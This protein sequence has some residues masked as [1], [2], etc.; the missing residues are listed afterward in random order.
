MNIY[1]TEKT[2]SN[3]VKKNGKLLGIG[4]A[5]LL[6]LAAF[7]SGLHIGSGGSIKSP[8]E[9]GLLTFFSSWSEPNKEAD[10]NEFWR[11][12]NLL[13]K[14]FVASTSTDPV[15][16]SDRI[17]GAIEGLVGSYGDPYTLFL[18]PE[19]AAEFA[20][21]IGGEFSGVGMEVGLRNG[22][23]TVI[24]PLSDSPAEKAGVLSG[25]VVVKIDGTA[26]DGMS[27]EEAVRLIRGE[28][29]S[30]VTL[31]IYRE[32]ELEFKDIEITRDLITIPTVDTEVKNGVYIIRLYNFNALSETKMQEAL[33][34]Y[35]R[36]RYKKL[37]LDLRG[38]PGGY[39]Q[40]AI[41]IA[42][43]FLPEGSAV[44]RE[45]FGENI[46]EQVYRS[47]GKKVANFNPDNLVVLIDG[48]SAS[49]SEILAGALSEQK[50]ATT[51]GT[52]TF[53]KGSV[54]ELIKLPSG[55][56]LKVTVARWLT[57]NGISLSEDGLDPMV[58][59]SRTP[60]QV[61]ADEDP[62]EAAA[63]EWLSGNHSIGEKDAISLLQ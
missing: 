22:L 47:Q 16:V 33:D 52:K 63:L 24:A 2:K 7:F 29:G 32:G 9:A 60:Q 48:G 1:G 3:G 49:A 10:L 58:K 23:I 35:K 61:V 41:A 11:V 20:E 44:V 55:A 13:E 5:V 12:W 45:H 46:E 54:Q 15:T 18:P 37:I 43:Y 27:I 21:D 51:I 8:M 25:D 17:N 6:A 59:I 30:K 42:G 4:L 34:A 28:Q 31:T 57:P 26:T 53:G 36:G 19:D 40:S 56:S 62:Q 14:K 50:V 38:N 39:L